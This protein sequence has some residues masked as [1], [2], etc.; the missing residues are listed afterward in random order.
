MFKLLRY[1]SI[2]SLLSVAVVALLLAMFYRHVALKDLVSMGERH[3]VALTRAFS[4][5]IWL[6]FG[7]FLSSASA[8]DDEALRN[9]PQT[10]RLH[11]EVLAQMRGL[12]VLK[13]KIYDLS[14]RTVFSTEARQIGEDKSSNSGYLSARGGKA[15]SALTHR[16]SFSAFEGVVQDRDV[17][18]SYIPVQRNGADGPIEGVFELYYDV[19]QLVRE[20][21]RTQF[22]LVLGV[23][24]LLTVLYGVLYF[25]VRWA[26]NVMKRQDHARH[27]AERALAESAENLR[28][29][30]ADLERFAY[31]ASHDLQ[32]PLRMINSYA[33]LLARRYKGKLDSEAD[34]FIHYVLDGATRMQRLIAD[35]LAYSRIEANKTKFEQTECE[36]L[37]SQVLH[38]LRLAIEECGAVVTHGCLPE[39]KADRTQLGQ[40]LQNLIGNA[41]KY[42]DSKPPEIH[43]GCKRDGKEWLFSVK[44]N[45][46]GIDRKYAERIFVI[47]QRLHT[48]E[49][50]SGTGI[51][52]AIC[53]RIVER[54][55]GKIW[56]ESDPGNGATFYFTLPAL[57]P[58]GDEKFGSS[59]PH[60]RNET[61]PD[62]ALRDTIG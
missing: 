9:H 39:L 42:R 4:N 5:H 23:V 58:N 54:H 51:G 46:I 36:S 16:D 53:R 17:I 41:I 50:Y 26:E 13:I 44:D 28:R 6:I 20:L 1:F 60:D 35:L 40:L 62:S 32:E 19:T 31:A 10:A 11:E 55:G 33:Q 2:T 27:Q 12:S 52:L 25:I 3:N 43:V 8:I 49:Q 38:D 14:G 24:V 7:S 48:R 45:G 57:T 47:F 18:E 37:F 59:L 22:I 15:A 29:S 61:E 30:N 34:E 56:V 21:E